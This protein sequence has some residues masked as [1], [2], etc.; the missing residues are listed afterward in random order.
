MSY[1]S[2]VIAD[3]VSYYYRLGEAS[4]SVAVDAVGSQNGTI[5]GSPTLGVA[6]LIPSEPADTC[7]TFPKTTTEFIDLPLATD[8]YSSANF[9]IEV[10]FN[11][12][13]TPGE[14]QYLYRCDTIEIYLDTSGYFHFSMWNGASYQTATSITPML[15]GQTYHAVSVFHAT[16]GMSVYMDGSLTDTNTNTAKPA[17]TQIYIQ[18]AGANTGNVLH[19]FD[20]SMDDVALYKVALTPTQIASH[21]S[22]TRSAALFSSAIAAS[23][24]TSGSITI[25]I[26]IFSSVS[27][28]AAINGTLSPKSSDVTESITVSE[29]LST[30]NQVIASIS[31]SMTVS[32]LYSNLLMASGLITE[33]ISAT[34]SLSSQNTAISDIVES[35]AF[36]SLFDDNGDT[37][38]GVVLNTRNYANSEYKQF[39]FNSLA[40]HGSSYYAAKNDGIYELGGG[41][42]DTAKI[43]ASI[44]TGILD[45]GSEHLKRV[46]HA[47][48]AMK[49]DD[50]IAL[51]TIVD[52][53]DGG[54]KERW[55]EITQTSSSLRRRK[56][57]LGRGVK[58]AYWQF[59]LV[60]NNG[61]DFDINGLELLPVILT[62]KV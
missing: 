58:S 53:D 57:T 24:N 29:V 27:I 50:A 22:Q 21:A 48:V 51:K 42:D 34:D 11:V 3:G 23:A 59:E 54:T 43:A 30:I 49:N 35:I 44:K 56:L 37:Y 1:S 52:N 10:V 61:G 12:T 60:N 28:S 9:S 38:T 55:Y 39:D 7:F 16:N 31:E 6:S 5:N 8:I 26:N 14:I 62:R 45:F 47:Y 4:G 32:E 15:S 25:P 46:T 20:G 41:L 33:S 19:E 18:I 17:Y 40:K 13:V 2:E 36:I